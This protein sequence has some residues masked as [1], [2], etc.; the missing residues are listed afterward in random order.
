MV[1]SIG[2]SVARKGF[3]RPRGIGF[4]VVDDAVSCLAGCFFLL[5][6]TST[7]VLKPRGVVLCVRVVLIVNEIV[8]RAEL[9]CRGPLLVQQLPVC[10]KRARLYCM[11]SLC[12]MCQAQLF[13]RKTIRDVYPLPP[14]TRPF[15]DRF[16]LPVTLTPH[17]CPIPCGGIPAL[18]GTIL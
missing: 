3:Y 2:A 1:R 12:R 13:L 8:P 15:R 5:L 16:D 4:I 9:L 17:N 11:F 18:L 7:A 10:K 14:P 6:A